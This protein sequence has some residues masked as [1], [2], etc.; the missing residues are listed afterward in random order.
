MTTKQYNNSYKDMHPTVAQHI[1]REIVLATMNG[2]SAADLNERLRA[3]GTTNPDHTAVIFTESHL[4]QMATGI[5]AILTEVQDKAPHRFTEAL[6]LVI[7]M[8]TGGSYG[9]WYRKWYIPHAL[10]NGAPM[11]V[12]AASARKIV[13]ELKQG[14]TR[15]A[16]SI[17]ITNGVHA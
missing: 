8:H 3:N 15:T 16:G 9:P 10:K 2:S 11:W 6:N 17:E 4:S 13:T 1:G 14:A 7:N 12:P 5:I